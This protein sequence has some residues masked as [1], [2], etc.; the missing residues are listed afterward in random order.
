M[1]QLDMA[2][3]LRSMAAAAC[4]AATSVPSADAALSLSPSSTS[5]PACESPLQTA[6]T[7]TKGSNGD[8]VDQVRIFQNLK[9]L[10]YTYL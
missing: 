8:E 10:V 4:L 7:K 2:S 1:G 6:G 9:I 5:M 3:A